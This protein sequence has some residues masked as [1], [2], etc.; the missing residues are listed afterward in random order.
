MD[1][2]CLE[3]LNKGLTYCPVCNQVFMDFGNA[4]T[5]YQTRRP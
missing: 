1:K 2:C 4:K 5:N 3:A